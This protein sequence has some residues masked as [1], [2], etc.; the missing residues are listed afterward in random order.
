MVAA[1]QGGASPLYFDP[2]TFGGPV[3]KPSGFSNPSEY[4][5]REGLP[6]FFSK[7]KSDKHV[8]IGY[9]GGSITRADNQYRVQS[10]KFIKSLFPETKITGINAGVSGTG[11]DLGA[12]RLNEQLL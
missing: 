10:I 8:C 11:T 5:V 12:C 7:L 6:N 3:I 2:E 9:L 4:T 1:S